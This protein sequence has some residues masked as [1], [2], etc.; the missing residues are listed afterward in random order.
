[1]FHVLVEFHRK[2]ARGFKSGEQWMVVHKRDRSLILVEK[3]SQ[4]R[5]AIRETS[6]GAS[7]TESI[8]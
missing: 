6:S 2:A 8:M 3:D 4:Q 1:M 5:S 7:F